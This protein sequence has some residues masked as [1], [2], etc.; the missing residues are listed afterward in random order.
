VTGFTVNHILYRVFDAAEALLYVGITNDLAR[1]FADHEREQ[2]WWPD[3]VD[4][5]TEFFPDRTALEI[6]EV[7]AIQSEHPRHNIRHTPR[8]PQLR[9]P[10][11]CVL[12]SACVGGEGSSRSWSWEVRTGWAGGRRVAQYVPVVP[13][14][15]CATRHPHPVEQAVLVPY[16]LYA[17]GEC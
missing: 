5:K 17:S 9:L 3:V 14:E 10:P 1:R 16:S 12:E 7:L 8:D 2:S 11:V 13:C 4:C 6:A 15:A